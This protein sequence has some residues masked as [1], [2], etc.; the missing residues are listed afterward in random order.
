MY[1]KS[2]VEGVVGVVDVEQDDVP[3]QLSCE[4]EPHEKYEGRK[5]PKGDNQHGDMDVLL[6]LLQDSHRDEGD[7][8]GEQ[9]R[10]LKEQITG[11]VKDP[12]SQ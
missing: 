6:V 10:E 1:Q 11:P 12:H 7:G 3:S 2:N 4:M 5:S 8:E 9:A